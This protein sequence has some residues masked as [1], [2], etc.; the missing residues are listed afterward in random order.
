MKFTIITLLS[1]ICFYAHALPN[2]EGP[3]TSGGGNALVYPDG[4]LRFLDITPNLF[5]KIFNIYN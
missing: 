1:L 4:T 2:S 3:W 5:S